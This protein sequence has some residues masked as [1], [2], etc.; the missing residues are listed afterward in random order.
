MLSSATNCSSDRSDSD[1][2]APPSPP[3]LY[4]TWAGFTVT[5]QG[6]APKKPRHRSLDSANQFGGL[7]MYRDLLVHV[8]GERRRTP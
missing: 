8:D 2:A 5:L 7:D 6:R 4:L 1:T 3:K